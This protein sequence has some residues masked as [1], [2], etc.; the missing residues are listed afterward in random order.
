MRKT[1]LVIA[2]GLLLAVPFGAMAATPNYS[3]IQ[4]LY[5]VDGNVDVSNG[6][7]LDLE[8]FQLKLSLG[9]TD[10]IYGRVQYSE[11]GIDKPDNGDY[12]FFSAGG[13]AHFP[14]GSDWYQFDVFGLV[15]FET[16]QGGDFDYDASGYGVRGGIRWQPTDRIEISPFYEYFDYGELDKTNTSVDGSRYG[17][18]AVV[19]ITDALAVTAVYQANDFDL[20]QAKSG[21]TLD[22]G[23]KTSVGIRYYFSSGSS[24][25]VY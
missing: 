18:Q 7:T 10:H 25:S 14:I 17:V 1:S 19:G 6:K 24:S 16:I 8:G 2:M 5:V 3:Y 11:I 13:G 9:L 15:S 22:F 21:N 20:K 4:G 12:R 23:D